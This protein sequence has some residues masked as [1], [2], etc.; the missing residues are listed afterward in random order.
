MIFNFGALWHHRR[1]N[2][3]DPTAAMM[4]CAVGLGKSGCISLMGLVCV[5]GFNLPFFILCSYR[6]RTDG[7][8]PSENADLIS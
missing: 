6:R 8:N 7:I 3:V 1:A 2:A 5:V 4:R